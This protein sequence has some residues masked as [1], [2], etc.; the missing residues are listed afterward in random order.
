MSK[1]RQNPQKSQS[2]KRGDDFENLV[3]NLERLLATSDIKIERNVRLR[4]IETTHGTREVDILL[5]AKV[6]EGEYKVAIECR[7][8]KKVDD[9]TW[10][11]ALIRRREDL[12]LDK[13]IAVSKSNFSSAMMEKAK[14]HDITLRKINPIDITEIADWFGVSQLRVTGRI[15]ELYDYEIFTVVETPLTPQALQT[16]KD[17]LI[18]AKTKYANA[19]FY[20]PRS[21][22]HASLKF[23]W[24]D[25]CR[26]HPDL[27]AQWKD[28]ALRS[29]SPIFLE[30]PYKM[31]EIV[32]VSKVREVRI[33]AIIF[34]AKLSKDI[35]YAPPS[36]I[37]R[38]QEGGTKLVDIV[39]FEKDIKG[40]TF[41][42]EVRGSNERVHIDYG[43]SSD[44]STSP[45]VCHNR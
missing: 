27:V 33:E 2:S 17:E 15:T 14:V 12:G 36:Q 24:D 22:G 30:V 42:V 5:T 19:Y 16:L 35:S 3:E 45:P 11:D 41:S 21:G 28:A 23:I 18:L 31:P 7:D 8:R 43:V 1:K 44:S 29:D 25:F 37:L 13:V 34:K 40:H 39:R 38:Y 6:G 10:M 9:I 26:R 20:V 32:L 4:D